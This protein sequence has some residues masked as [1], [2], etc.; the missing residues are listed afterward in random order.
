MRRLFSIA[1][2][3]GVGVL[4]AP[5]ADAQPLRDASV[6][7]VRVEQGV[8]EGSHQKGF[9]AFLGVPFAAPP[10]GDNRWRAPLP[11]PSWQG[12]RSAT[13]F[14][15]SCWQR[16]DKKGFGPWTHEYVVQDAVSED[17]L[18]LNVWRPSTPHARKLPVMVWI[19]G[20]GFNSGSGSV[21]IYNGKHLAERGVIV[22]TINYRLGAL[23]FLAHP[24]ITR[25][26]NGAPPGNFGLQ[27]QI[28]ALRWIQHNIA[29]FGGDPKRVTI[30]GQSAGSMAVHALVAS[31][32]AKGLFSGAIAESGIPLPQNTL[33]A[34]EKAGVSFAQKVGATTLADLR[35]L[36]PEKLA[37]AGGG[38]IVDG[39]LLTDSIAA[40]TAHGQFNDVPMIVGQNTDENISLKP[41]PTGL[42]VEDYETALS[43]QYGDMAPAFEAAYPAKD[44]HARAEAARQIHYEKG[45]ASIWQW[46]QS[47]APYAKAPSYAYLYTHP[48][49]G[50]ESKQWRVFHSSEI[51]YVFGTFDESPERGFT[52]TDRQVSKTISTDWLNFIRNGNPNGPGV[53]PWP[54]L[55]PAAPQMAQINAVAKKRPLVEPARLDLFKAYVAKGGVVGTF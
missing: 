7:R 44:D 15:A 27:D 26:A 8:L 2:L 21:P 45:L 52:A 37:G 4:M 42:S 40:M 18:F 3:A 16:V 32:L 11:A 51:P 20:G 1:L 47:R 13:T 48:E 30:A 54:T 43:K 38:P 12:A 23:G 14:G 33:E 50:P 22:V 53:S 49:T 36:P 6:A 5:L 25:E 17:C 31:P 10:I 35:A 34:A 19:H 55:N 46:A 39:K 9:D 28:A 41:A 29:Q 24:D